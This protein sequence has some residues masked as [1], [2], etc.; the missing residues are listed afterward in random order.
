MKRDIENE[1]G[2]AFEV[3]RHSVPVPEAGM[4]FTPGVWQAI[5]ARRTTRV[6]GLWA[7]A[8]TSCALAASL[9][10]GVLSSRPPQNPEPE[11]YV[12]AFLEGSRPVMYEVEFLNASLE[13]D[14]S[15]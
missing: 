9:M 15:R 8:L 3:Y 7:K 2:R 1:V 12:S 10:L 14:S 6:F 11:E 4:A 5:E 13:M